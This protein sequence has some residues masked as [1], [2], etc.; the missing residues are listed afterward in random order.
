MIVPAVFVGTCRE[1][2]QKIGDYL[3]GRMPWWKRLQVRLHFRRCPP[4][5]K[6]FRS[7][8]AT[9]KAV[10]SVKAAERHIEIPPDLKSRIED[11]FRK[12]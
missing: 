10:D 4:C 12:V 9:L 6:W 3:D 2:A 8:A 5:E 7:V 1:T 11:I